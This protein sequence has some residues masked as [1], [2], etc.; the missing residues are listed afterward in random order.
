[1]DGETGG[2]KAEV[3]KEVEREKKC[4]EEKTKR[5]KKE[6]MW[7]EE[8]SKARKNDANKRGTTAAMTP[9]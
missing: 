9:S 6:K 7:E 8:G 2:Q 3:K 1:M 4:R 5:Q